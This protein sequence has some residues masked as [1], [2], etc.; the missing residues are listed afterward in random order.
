LSVFRSLL[1]WSYIYFTLDP[2]LANAQVILIPKPEWKKSFAKCPGDVEL[3]LRLTSFRNLSIQYCKITHRF[4][5][6]VCYHPRAKACLGTCSVGFVRKRLSWVCVPPPSTLNLRTET[7]ADFKTLRLWTATQNS[8]IPTKCKNLFGVLGIDWR[9]ILSTLQRAD[10]FSRGS[11]CTYLW[12]MQANTHGHSEASWGCVQLHSMTNP[13]INSKSRDCRVQEYKYCDV[14]RCVA[15]KSTTWS[16]NMLRPGSSHCLSWWETKI[17]INFKDDHTNV[18]KKGELKMLLA[19]MSLKHR[20]D[21]LHLTMC[22]EQAS[23]V[24]HL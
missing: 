1:E 8:V 20:P 19:Y 6:W 24:V 15:E 3:H 16:V 23:L 17:F 12:R 22:T 4:G 7:D 13:P 14:Y 18:P 9:I 11:L 21:A 2:P 5:N 10:W